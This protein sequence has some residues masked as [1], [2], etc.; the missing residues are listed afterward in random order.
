M[1][2]KILTADYILICDED[3]KII[4]NGAVCFNDKIIEVGERDKVIENNPYARVKYL[5]K[6]SVI[7]PGLIN[8]HVHLEFSANKTILTYGDFVNWLQSIINKRDILKDRCNSECYEKA[9]TQMLE[10]G[11]VAFGAVS[12]FGDDLEICFNLPQRVVYFNEILGSNPD[13]SSKIC[14]NFEERVQKSFDLAS[15]GLIPAVSVHSAYSTHPVIAKFALD[16]ARKNNL[17]VTT[18]FMES[19]AERQWLDNGSG[20]FAKFLSIFAK[21]PKPMYNAMEF[22]TQFENLKTIF[23]HGVMCNKKELDIISK[24]GS[25]AHCV[26]SNRVLNNPLLEL[27]KVHDLKVNLTIGTDGLSSNISLNIWDELR[28][29]LFAHMDIDVLELSKQL[30]LASTRNGA[31]AL[32]LFGNTKIAKGKNAD[33]VSIVLPDCIEDE[34][35]LPLELILHTEKIKSGYING[36]RYV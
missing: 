4:K 21:D 33:I 17:L 29:A 5:S 7:M 3:F 24:T 12:S 22:L 32:N 26:V 8:T 19:K 28:A 23:V 6:N 34:K 1:K 36:E 9:T 27:K 10:S 20:D 11:V 2:V 16:I 25:L 31:K 14:S 30:I 15:D 13:F 35:Q 18:H